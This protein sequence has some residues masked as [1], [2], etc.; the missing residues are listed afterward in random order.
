MKDWKV[1]IYQWFFDQNIHIHAGRVEP[2]LEIIGSLLK[3]ERKEGIEEAI[4]EI[5]ELE[6]RSDDGGEYMTTDTELMRTEI[7]EALSEKQKKGGI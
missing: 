6:I 5:E 4:K 7:V 1:D 2:L 3:Q